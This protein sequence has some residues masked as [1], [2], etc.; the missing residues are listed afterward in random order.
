[1][2]L[3]D[4]LEARSHRPATPAMWSVA[5]IV[6]VAAV[7]TVKLSGCAGRSP[8]E[9]QDREVR[10]TSDE[11]VKLYPRYSPDNAWIAYAS[12]TAKPGMFA[13]FVIPPEG[14][15][16]RQISP[17][18]LSVYPLSWA[19][20]GKGVFCREAEG[21]G[22]YLYLIGLD[23]T[24]RLVDKGQELTRRIAISS[25]GKTE[26][27]ARF[28]KDNRD[29]GIRQIGGKLEFLAETP[30]WEE[31]AAFGPGPG[32]VTVVSVPSYLASKS[33][34]STWSPATR[35]YS[36]LPLP[37]GRKHEPAWSPDGT[38]LAYTGVT[39][40]QSDIWIYDPA[41]T[42][43]T[44]LIEDPQDTAS[45]TWSPDGEMLAF[46]RSTKT[47]HLFA[48]EPGSAD[49]RQLTDGPGRDFGVQ[50]SPD[51]KWITFLR[52]PP[53]GSGDRG[54]PSLCVMP[55]AGGDVKELDLK[56]VALPMSGHMTLA[57]SRDGRQI[58]FNASDGSAKLDIYRIGRDGEGLARVTVEPGEE[59]EPQWSP[60]GEFISYTQAGGG[61]LEVAVVPAHGGLSRVIS[62]EGVKSEVGVWSPR[63]DRIA[64]VAYSADGHFELWITSV[65]A[66]EKRRRL[67]QGEAPVWPMHWAADG[68]ELVAMQ[69]KGRDWTIQAISVENGAM[70]EVGRAVPLLSGKDMLCEFPPGAERY[71]KLVYPAGV[72][73]SDGQ[74]RSDLYMIRAR[75]SLGT[76]AA[77]SMTQWLPWRGH[78]AWAGSF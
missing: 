67:T 77:S 6:L 2:N 31:E 35:I 26:L 30:A 68:T 60:D 55:A 46:I 33:T 27:V 74:D 12:H 41:S 53:G 63:S 25:D 72:I 22:L 50:A 61:R 58:A 64:H 59:V 44:A 76:R 10:L 45:P 8:A 7:V 62:P 3:H 19:A 14:G 18:S 24:V 51:G 11:T 17:D 4:E 13:T 29:M 71:R 23:G 70:R 37:E 9:A 56:G 73:L 40:G 15:E 69:K 39:D 42:R 57:W 34:I 66:P 20:D 32:E 54:G 38:L 65:A 52:K 75:E 36:P 21:L 48:G 1:M 43:A 49:R 5:A 78:I 28:N 16:P 47:S